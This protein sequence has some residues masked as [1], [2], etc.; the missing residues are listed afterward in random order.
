MPTDQFD[1]LDDN[2]EDHFEID[3]GQFRDPE[4]GEFES[5][6]APPDYDADTDRFRAENGEFK[7]RSTDLFDE[8]EEVRQDSLDPMG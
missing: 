2:R 1:D 4:S 7:D 3:T 6:G 5:G 8:V